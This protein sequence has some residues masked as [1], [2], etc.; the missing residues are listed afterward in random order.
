MTEPNGVCR[1]GYYCILKA[2]TPM[3]LDGV[4]GD[5]CPVGKHCPN[6]S[7]T[8]QNCI[9]GTYRYIHIAMFVFKLLVGSYYGH[10]LELLRVVN[11]NFQGSCDSEQYL[12][13]MGTS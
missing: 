7:A 13:A 10:Y 2:T 1:P 12:P 8:P 9:P 3:P 5:I 11:F 6:G 4:T